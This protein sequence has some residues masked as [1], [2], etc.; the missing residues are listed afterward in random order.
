MYTDSDVYSAE[1]HDLPVTMRS[2]SRSLSTGENCIVVF[3]ELGC[4]GSDSIFNGTYGDL[5]RWKNIIKSWKTCFISRD[6]AEVPEQVDEIRFFIMADFLG[7][8]F[9]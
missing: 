2:N 7:K 3:S 5:G 4:T 8:V 1:C 6:T 9:K